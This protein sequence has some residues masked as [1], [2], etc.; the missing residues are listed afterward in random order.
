MHHERGRK[1]EK[2]NKS[3]FYIE[4][5]PP[6]A[7]NV[8]NSVLFVLDWRQR[9]FFLYSWRP[10]CEALTASKGHQS[11]TAL[12]KGVVF[13]FFFGRNIQYQ[14]EKSLYFYI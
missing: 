11:T 7:E 10:T 5:T 3:G 4:N 6:A 12:S 14:R 13:F 9:H 1:R 2:A 8:A